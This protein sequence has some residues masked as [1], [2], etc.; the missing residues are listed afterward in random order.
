MNSSTVWNPA[1]YVSKLIRAGDLRI[2]A[3]SKPR[4]SWIMCADALILSDLSRNLMGKDGL[5]GR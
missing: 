5:E 1:N 2:I 3:T 4:I